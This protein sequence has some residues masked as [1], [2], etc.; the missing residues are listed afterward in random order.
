MTTPLKEIIPESVKTELKQLGYKFSG[1][2]FRKVTDQFTLIIDF[3]KSSFNTEDDVS[4][5][6]ELGVFREDFYEFM[7]HEK[8]PKSIRS[9]KCS[10]KVGNGFLLGKGIPQ[11]IYNL[12]PSTINSIQEQLKHDFENHVYSFVKKIETLKDL[13]EFQ[14]L[15]PIY[16]D[17]V[18]LLIGFGLAKIREIDK[19]SE[20]VNEYL[21]SGN[22]PI[23]WKKRIVEESEKLKIE[24]KN[25]ANTQQAI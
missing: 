17:K 15:D 24:I 1:S 18:A 7:F 4:F 3:W 11:Q 10:I 6:F 16:C 12:T 14:K 19:A 21:T 20:Y 25:G 2:T 23:D 9:N 22:F 13:S 5:W 8:S